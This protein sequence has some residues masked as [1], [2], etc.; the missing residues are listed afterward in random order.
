LYYSSSTKSQANNYLEYP[1]AILFIFFGKNVRGLKMIWDR[2]AIMG[3]N[4]EHDWLL[5]EDYGDADKTA[6]SLISCM[7]NHPFRRASSIILIIL[8]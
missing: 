6:W 2:I 4:E 7:A 5:R 1:P 3:P 8:E